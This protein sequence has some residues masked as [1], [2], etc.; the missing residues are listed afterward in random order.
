MRFNERCFEDL[1]EMVDDAYKQ[2]TKE[3]NGQRY[4]IMGYSMGA[5]IAFEVV[6]KLQENGYYLPGHVFFCAQNSPSAQIK[7]NMRGLSEDEFFQKVLEL[8]GTEEELVNNKE[9]RKIF[10]KILRSDYEAF[11][12]YEFHAGTKIKCDCSDTEKIYRRV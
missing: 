10:G 9:I 2:I 11:E 12:T 3:L 8:G 5:I 1:N 7:R 4:A 6:R